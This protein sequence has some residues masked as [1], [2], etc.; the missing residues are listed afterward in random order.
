MATL[1]NAVAHI[2]WPLKALSD[3]VPLKLSSYAKIACEKRVKCVT[4]PLKWLVVRCHTCVSVSIVI[5]PQMCSGGDSLIKGNGEF[6]VFLVLLIMLYI[7]RCY[8]ARG[9]GP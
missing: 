3:K 1:D 9:P 4:N 2:I 8:I 6:F 7:D 5:V